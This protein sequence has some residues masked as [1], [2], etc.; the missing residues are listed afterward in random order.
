MTPLASAANGGGPNVHNARDY[1]QRVKNT[2]GPASLQY[3]L[4]LSTLRGYRLRELTPS[5]VID[6]ISQ[7][8]RGNIE[9]LLG[10]SSFLP[11][12]YQIVERDGMVR[13]SPPENGHFSSSL[14]LGLS[15]HIDAY[16]SNDESLKVWFDYFNCF[17]P[18]DVL[19]VGR[20]FL[21]HGL[22]SHVL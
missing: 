18:Y 21:R 16:G 17:L 13:G 2:L 15:S 20:K 1:V 4:F 14:K 12:G 11:P 7:L 8:F 3:R 5:E 22:L 10:F 6:H 19:V 9:L